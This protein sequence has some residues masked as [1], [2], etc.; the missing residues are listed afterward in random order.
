MEAGILLSI[1][2]HARPGFDRLFL[3]SHD[4]GTFWLCAPLV[5]AMAFWHFGRGEKGQARLWLLVGL[6]TYALQELLKRLVDRPRPELWPRLVNESSFSF[7]SGHALASASL[8]PLLAYDLTRTK[9]RAVRVAAMA[10]AV[11]LSLLIGFGRLYLGVHWP[12]DVAAGWAI[13]AAQALVA[14]RRLGRARGA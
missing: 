9:A 10:T 3:L 11:A 6:S 4:L 2:A 1:H 13:G 8:L 12:S 7:P 14:I 5:L